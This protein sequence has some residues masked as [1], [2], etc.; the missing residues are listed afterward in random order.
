MKHV[1]RARAQEGHY[2]RYAVERDRFEYPDKSPGGH[3]WVGN[4]PVNGVSMEDAQAYIEWKKS[5][6]GEKLRLPHENEWEKAARGVDGRFFPWGDHFDPT[7]CKMKESRNVPYPEPEP[8]GAFPIDCSPYGARDMAGSMREI[9]V[10]EVGGSVMPVMRGGC[11][12]DTGLFCRVAFRHVTQPDFVNTGLG[13][14][15]AKDL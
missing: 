2:W 11:W 12:S 3:A 13:F 5:V 10:T 14:R 1:P 4:L 15:L 7:F 8:V 9:C 6:T